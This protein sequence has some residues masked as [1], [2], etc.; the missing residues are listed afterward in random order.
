MKDKCFCQ[1][2]IRRRFNIYKEKLLKNDGFSFKKLLLR[3][4]KHTQ[5]QS[6]YDC[7]NLLFTLSRLVVL[8]IAKWQQRVLC[9][10]MCCVTAK[11]HDFV[12]S[13]FNSMI[14]TCVLLLLF[15]HLHIPS[16]LVRAKIITR[17]LVAYL[18]IYGYYLYEISALDCQL[19]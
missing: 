6:S 16:N 2:S 9:D 11:T 4:R 8:L 19:P 17:R 14:C 18:L 12:Y 1:V 10:M 5:T 3:I 13:D 7:E 15:D